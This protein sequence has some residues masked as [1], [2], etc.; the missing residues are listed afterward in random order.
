MNDVC[1]GTSLLDHWDWCRWIHGLC[2]VAGCN[3]EA[4]I[5]DRF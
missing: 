4:G 1:S 3:I 5:S 2:D